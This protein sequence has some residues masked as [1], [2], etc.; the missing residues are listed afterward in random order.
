MEHSPTLKL[1]HTSEVAP[2][3]PSASFSSSSIDATKWQEDHALRDPKQE[4]RALG[5]AELKGMQGSKDGEDKETLPAV[6]VEYRKEIQGLNKRLDLHTARLAELQKLVEKRAENSEGEPELSSNHRRSSS[7]EEQNERGPISYL[8]EVVVYFLTGAA[9]YFV[10]RYQAENIYLEKEYSERRKERSNPAPVPLNTCEHLNCEKKAEIRV[11]I[12]RIIDGV[13]DEV[14]PDKNFHPGIDTQ[15]SDATELD[16][17]S[18]KPG[19][20]WSS[21]FWKKQ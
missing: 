13:H 12:E 9:C 21:F 5:Q 11:T 8:A 19:R 18:G 16:T 2:G 1:I 7:K 14:V 15:Q 17:Q 6:V 4:D 10:G 3:A 20:S